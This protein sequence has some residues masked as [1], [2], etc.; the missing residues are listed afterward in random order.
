MVAQKQKIS[1]IVGSKPIAHF[2]KKEIA[3]AKDLIE[4]ID[5]NSVLGQEIRKAII[6]A[7]IKLAKP[8][9]KRAGKKDLEAEMGAAAIRELIYGLP[10]K[11]E[12]KKTE[13]SKGKKEI[14]K[15]KAT[16][17]PAVKTAKSK[18]AGQTKKS[19]RKQVKRQRTRRPRK[20]EIIEAKMPK[21]TMLE[22]ISA[23]IKAFGARN[24]RV[25]IRATIALATA[26]LAFASGVAI[27]MYL[28]HNP[29]KSK[30]PTEMIS[31]VAGKENTSVAYYVPKGDSSFIK[32]REGYSPAIKPVPKE[33]EPK[34]VAPAKEEPKKKAIAE[35]KAEHRKVVKHKINTAK[36]IAKKQEVKKDMVVQDIP[37]LAIQPVIEEVKKPIVVSLPDNMRYN[38]P[39]NKLEINIDRIVGG[40]GNGITVKFM[41]MPINEISMVKDSIKGERN[42]GSTCQIRA[43]D[44]TTCYVHVAKSGWIHKKAEIMFTKIKKNE[45]RIESVNTTILTV[46]NEGR[47]G[48]DIE[49]IDEMGLAIMPLVPDSAPTQ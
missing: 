15:A 1:K 40:K 13:N 6:K 14:S 44:G 45:G 23:R 12:G 7:G 36:T 38:E 30:A 3:K 10:P 43:I 20:T 41:K 47:Y 28:K 46:D 8:K 21:P 39:K 29:P 19:T 2:N 27:N 16:G 35:K 33:P 25:M 26:A 9:T 48:G 42:S 32:A 4:K 5:A 24:R 34:A 17:K 18:R 31:K 11:R 22:R 37:A 49:K